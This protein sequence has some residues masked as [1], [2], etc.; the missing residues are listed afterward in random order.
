MNFSRA[1]AIQSSCQWDLPE[2]FHVLRNTFKGGKRCGK[3]F[4]EEKKSQ[5]FGHKTFFAKV[6]SF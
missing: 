4:L 2:F 3:S 1:Y 6:F 5:I